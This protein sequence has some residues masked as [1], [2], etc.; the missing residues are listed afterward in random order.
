MVVNDDLPTITSRPF[1][2]DK[3][4]KDIRTVTSSSTTSQSFLNDFQFLNYIGSPS[5]Y[6]GDFL[7]KGVKDVKQFELFKQIVYNR[8]R[9][10]FINTSKNKNE[11]EIIDKYVTENWIKQ[12]D[13][14]I[15]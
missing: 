8:C 11:N 4:P 7:K 13:V 6:N 14:S 2:S 3:D 1:I 9:T 5:Q 15:L 10:G 12:N